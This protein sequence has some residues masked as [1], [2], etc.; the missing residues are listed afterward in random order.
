MPV[1]RD[2]V[3]PVSRLRDFLRDFKATNLLLEM[4]ENTD[5]QL[6]KSLEDAL[7][8]I[9]TAYPPVTDYSINSVTS[10]TAVRDRAVLN[11]LQSNMIKSAR[12][13][14]SYRDQGGVDI[15]E[16][17]VYGRYVNIYNILF[18]KNEAHIQRFKTSDNVNSAYGG[19]E[20]EYYDEYDNHY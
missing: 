11:V 9:N 20:S 6:Q 1:S 10:W 13:M 2:Y 18:A 4:E 17:D 3:T 12:N 15:Q 5:D 8:Y 7:D 19:V 14:F 16:E